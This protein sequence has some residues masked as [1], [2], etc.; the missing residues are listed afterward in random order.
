MSD[1][2]AAQL[3]KLEAEN[4]RLA[5]L[6]AQATTALADTNNRMKAEA[7]LREQG[8][9]DPARVADLAL[10]HL[11]G[12]EGDDWT[13]KLQP[14]AELGKA[15]PAPAPP[16]EPPTPAIAAPSPG[17]TGVTPADEV[18]SIQ[19]YFQQSRRGQ[20]PR[21]TRSLLEA[22]AAGT[23]EPSG[24]ARTAATTD[25]LTTDTLRHTYETG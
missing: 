7:W 23:V 9:A 18:L 16:Q 21:D 3:E 19:D 4:K 20:Q 12:V 25:R 10:P 22:M 8:I 15:A 5:E 24:A 1:D 13:A 17:S 6:N 11:R 2:L 14:F